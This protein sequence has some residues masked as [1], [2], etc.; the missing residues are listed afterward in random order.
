MRSIQLMCA[1]LIHR[2]VKPGNVLVTASDHIYLTDFGVTKRITE[3][4]GLTKTGA[5]VGTPDYVA[6]EQI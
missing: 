1:G 6:P 5:L 4:T 3:A 2:D